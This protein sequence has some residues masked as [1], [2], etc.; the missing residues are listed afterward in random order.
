MK[1]K[2]ILMGTII[3]TIALTGCGNKTNNNV[4]EN[5]SVTPVYYEPQTETGTYTQPTTAAKIDLKEYKLLPVE[6]SDEELESKIRYYL[7]DSADRIIREGDKIT[8]TYTITR[9][10]KQEPEQTGD[11]VMGE[12]SLAAGLDEKLIG[13][14]A[15]YE[16]AFE[17]ANADG[18]SM[19]IALKINSVEEKLTNAYV[20]EVTNGACKN[21]QEFLK[22]IE[23]EMK[24]TRKMEGF[25]SLLAYLKDSEL[26]GDISN[27]V[28]AEYKELVEEY[29]TY[30][31][32]PSKLPQMFG[33]TTQEEF[34]EYLRDLADTNIREKVLY[35][36]FAETYGV[37]VTNEDYVSYVEGLKS[38]YS[39]EQIA[40]LYT[41]EEIKE[42]ILQSK[43]I[44][45]VY[46]A[47][48]DSEEP[49]TEVK[50]E[51]TNE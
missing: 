14:Q 17:F 19:Q 39:E 5:P 42:Q 12:N 30:T 6:I 13:Q 41:E 15:S 2:K 35:A 45:A 10:G 22:Y 9:D 11:L 26:I 43:V 40:S 38:K 29:K 51:T 47:S 7:H 44:D 1:L 49:T 16:G 25:A 50:T 46:A 36:Q 21:E 24:A 18:T 28:E 8:I 32:D 33:Y 4:E 31:D 23:D 48:E 3:A 20:S 37:S 27:E 34:E